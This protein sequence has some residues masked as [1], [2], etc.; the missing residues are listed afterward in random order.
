[1]N[2]HDQKPARP[3][4]RPS[5]LDEEYDQAV[6]AKDESL[7]GEP[8]SGDPSPKTPAERGDG[9][10]TRGQDYPPSPHDPPEHHNDADQGGF[11]EAL[12]HFFGVIGNLL[13]ESEGAL[14]NFFSAVGNLIGSWLEAHGDLD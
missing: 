13:G 1:M 3:R 5:D 10:A 6:D 4:R 12:G 14:G 7:F 9:Q 2:V 11:E 8:S